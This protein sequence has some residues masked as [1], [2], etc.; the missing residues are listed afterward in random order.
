MV[1]QCCKPP[2]FLHLCALPL[3]VTVFLWW[4]L[5]K[6]LCPLIM[7]SHALDFSAIQPQT[8]VRTLPHT[9]THRV[10]GSSIHLGLDSC[11]LFHLMPN[12]EWSLDAAMESNQGR[13]RYV[14]MHTHTDIYIS[15][16]IYIYTH[17]NRHRQQ[18]NS[19]KCLWWSSCLYHTCSNCQIVYLCDGV[20]E[21]L[22]ILTIVH[23]LLFGGGGSES[24]LTVAMNRAAIMF[25][26][27]SPTTLTA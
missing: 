27:Q 13:L 26:V 23:V 20:E 11:T 9:F 24:L 2:F 8:N 18:S 25:I 21:F 4:H 12:Q 1:E 6:W 10:R 3:K 16:Y 14:Y 7:P 22:I 5:T 15:K 17:T 19:K